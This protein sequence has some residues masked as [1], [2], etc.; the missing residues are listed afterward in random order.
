MKLIFIFQ[1]KYEACRMQ[2]IA[3]YIYTLHSVGSHRNRSLAND[4]EIRCVVHWTK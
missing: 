1:P 3:H 4:W 2:R